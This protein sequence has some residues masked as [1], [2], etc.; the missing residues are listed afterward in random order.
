MPHVFPEDHPLR[1]A[2]SKSSCHRWEIENSG[3]LRL[4]LLQE[5]VTPK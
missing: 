3:A 4:L 5:D 2:H 1:V